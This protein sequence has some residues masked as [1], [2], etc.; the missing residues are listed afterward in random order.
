MTTSDNDFFE[1]VRQQE[2]ETTFKPKGRG[3]RTS[4]KFKITDVRKNMNT[5]VT[6]ANQVVV[7]FTRF[8]KYALNND[9]I[10][11]LADA[12]AAEIE[13]SPRLQKLAAGASKV[14]PHMQLIQA[15]GIIFLPRY[16][17]Y[18]ADTKGETATESETYSAP[19]AS[20]FSVPPAVSSNGV[21]PGGEAPPVRMW[22]G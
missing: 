11:L 6:S 12:L 5:L 21:A 13:A 20:P 8:G 16:L 18:V 2:E 15:A 3:S 9:E 22:Q 14:G 10:K 1:A 4:S 17:Q 7:N 19:E